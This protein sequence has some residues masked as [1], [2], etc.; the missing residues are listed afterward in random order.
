MHQWLNM[1]YVRLI[2]YLVLNYEK[3]FTISKIFAGIWILYGGWERI[4][5]FPNKTVPCKWSGTIKCLYMN[6]H[7]DDRIRIYVYT[8]RSRQD[9]G[10]PHVGHMNLAIWDAFAGPC[11]PKANIA[12]TQTI[13]P[14]AVLVWVESC[15]AICSNTF[16][17]CFSKTVSWAMRF[18]REN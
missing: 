15:L 8:A 12:L 7:N 18:A 14:R 2:Q 16:C 4:N 10:G 3:Y 6:K 11:L 13:Y 5:A 17:C 9:P 1:H